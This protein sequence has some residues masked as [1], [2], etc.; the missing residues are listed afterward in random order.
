MMSRFRSDL[1]RTLDERGYIHQ[2]TDADALDAAA[3]AG[4]VTAY[5]GYDCTAA[6]LHVGHLVSIMMLRTLQRTGHQ[7]IALVGGGTTKVG[8][9]SFRDESR[10]LLDDAAIEA[11]KAGIQ[12]NLESFLDFR[13][14]GARLVDNAAWLDELRYIPFLRD[15]GTH[16]TINRMLT[17]DSVRL[18]LER[19]QPLTLLEFN[20]MVMQ[21]YDFLELGRRFDCRL[22]MGGSDQWGN[23]VNGVELGRRIDGR[24]LFG[25]TTPL[26]T[27]ASGAK[28]GKTA[29][30]AVWLSPDR[31]SAFDYWQF[32][33]NTEDGD[34]G[35][36][37]KLFTELPLAE[38]AR[39]EA[40][41]GAEINEAKKILA[42]EATALAHG[43]AAAEEAAAAARAQFEGGVRG[44]TVSRGIAEGFRSVMVEAAKLEAGVS[45]LELFQLAGLAASNA[46]VRR[47]IRGGGARLNDNPI[48]DEQLIVDASALTG[49]TLK[50]SAGKKRHVLVRAA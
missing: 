31:L 9:P 32:W 11:N 4:P 24:Q 13:A 39:L 41:S 19:E 25:L 48:A 33:R 17:F 47:L 35:R 27:T 26:I 49:D 12:A 29:A 7:P 21:A 50:L 43:R 28:M 1:M 2:C 34:V 46:D 36:F 38:I 3:L 22:Q 42:L 14:G 5:V 15:F 16:F 37:L 18:R 23:I 40:L 8:D 30:G 44:M 20:Y 10:P 6:S 45:I